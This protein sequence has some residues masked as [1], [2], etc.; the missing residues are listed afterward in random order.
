MMGARLSHEE[1]LARQRAEAARMAQQNAEF[2][3]ALAENLP[4]EEA[5]RRLKL[6]QVREMDVA[7]NCR[8]CG[9]E[10]TAHDGHRRPF[11]WERD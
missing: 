8:R 2:R 10:A 5:R 9:T 11:W 1:W 7:L 6:K 3:F 4:L